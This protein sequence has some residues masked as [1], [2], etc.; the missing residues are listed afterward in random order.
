MI[1]PETHDIF[2]ASTP[3]GVVEI[4]FP[5]TDTDLRAELSGQPAAV[6]CFTDLLGA[7]ENANGVPVSLQNLD[8]KTLMLCCQKDGITITAPADYDADETGLAR[9]ELQKA[10]EVVET[11]EPINR[12]R[13]DVE[14]ADLEAAS[15][16]SFRKAIAVLDGRAVLDSA[17]GGILPGLRMALGL[18]VSALA[19]LPIMADIIKAR[20]GGKT[21][22]FGLKKSGKKYREKINAKVGAL[23]EQIAAGRNVKSLTP[24]E[25]AL[26]R[27]YSGRGGLTDNSQN[28]YYTP[29]P[30]AQGV[31]DLFGA[32][33]FTSGN[34]LEPST[35][36]GVFS[37]TKPAGM[38]ITGTEI[39]KISATVNAAL[40]PEDRILHQP[41]EKLAVSAPDDSFDA[42]I[43]NVP[44]GTRNEGM[45]FDPEH[46]DEKRI[47]RYFVSRVI[48]KTRPGGLIALIV[49]TGIIGNKAGP[50]CKFR[51]MIS[52]KAEFLGAHK[53]PSKTFG[54]QGTDTV[55]DV[56]VLRKHP[57]DLAGKIKHLPAQTLQVANVLWDEFIS[58]GYWLGEGRK[59][60]HGQYIPADKSKVRSMDQVIPDDGATPDTLKRALAVH[61]DSRIDWKMLD[62][63]EPVIPAYAAGDRR[64][65][66]GRDMEFD[67]TR[68]NEVQ[69]DAPEGAI[70]AALYGAGTL[71]ALRLIT[72]DLEGMLSLSSAQAFRVF[73]DFPNLLN[74]QQRMAVE[75]AQSQP[76]DACR[77][78]AFRGSL[79]GSIVARYVAQ[80][81]IGESDD[82]HRKHV[83]E[84][85]EREYAL[86][87]HPRSVK[88]FY[89]EGEAARYFGSYLSAVSE[90]G[91]VSDHLAGGVSEAIGYDPKNM[92]SVVEFLAKVKPDGVLSIDTVKAVY[93]GGEIKSLADVCGVDG[94]SITTNGEI[95]TSARYCAG[96]VYEKAGEFMAAMERETD[97]RVKAQF[98]AQIDL[99]MSKVKKTGIEDISFGLRDRWI[100][101]RYKIDFLNQHGYQF[102]YAVQG[103]KTSA[104]TGETYT[105]TIVS[106][107]SDSQIG[108][109]RLVS[110]AEANG[111]FGRQLEHYMQGRS[112]GFNVKDKGGVSADE[113]IEG[114]RELV[115]NLEEQFIIFMQSHDDFLEIERTY[116][117]TFNNYVAPE[118][119]ASDLGL[120]G[121]SGLVKGHWYQNQ[122]VRQLSEEGAGILGFDVGLGKTYTAIM[123]SLY[124]RQMGRSN[125]HLIVVPKAVL[126][127]WYQESK[128][129]IGNHDG[130]LFVGF[131]PKR[132][133]SAAIVQE[134]VWDENGNHKKNPH[135]GE[136]EYQDVLIE[137]M[138]EEVFAKMHS[139]PQ[140]NVGLVVMTYE[141]YATIPMREENRV[142]Y[143]ESWAE[144]SMM[145]MADLKKIGADGKEGRSYQE[146]QQTDRL[147]AEFS[148]DGTRKKAELPYFEDMGFDRVIVDEC[149]AFKNSFTMGSD[150]ERLAY[151]SNPAPSQRA[152]DMA[153][154]AAWLREKYDGKGVIALTATPVAN[155]P[156]EI[157]NMLSL[158]IDQSEFERLGIYT[159]DDF[160]RQFG[161]IQSV[162]KVR[163]SGEV[164]T[165][166][167]L[168][169]FK[170]LNS[171]RSLF[172]RFAI[173]KNA[174]DVDPDGNV[175]KLPEAVEMMTPVTMSVEQRDLYAA[176]REEA[177]KAG[178]PK[179][180]KSGEAR[181]MFAV[182]RDMDRVTTDIDLYNR[183]MTFI[184][185]AADKDKL[186]A[187]IASLPEE[188]TARVTD[189]DTGEK[190]D[191][192]VPKRAGYAVNGDTIT[193]IAHE[194]YEDAIVS[195]F[196]K[197]KI[198]YASHPL[199]P[200]YA[201][202]IDNMQA[203]LDSKGKQIVF[204][205]EKSQHGKLLRLIINNL[206]VSADQVA[207]INADTAGGE[208]LQ[209]ISDAY[210]RGDIRIIIANKKAEVGVNLQKGTSAIHHMTL[211]W[212]PASI[213][214]RNGRGV[215][216]GNT[217][218]QVRVYYYQAHGSFDEY[219][220]DLLKAKGNWIAALM[221]KNNTNDKAENSAAMGA[222]EQAA[223]LAD[224]REEFLAMV[225]AQ[226]E[227]KEAEARAKRDSAAK[228]NLTKLSSLTSRL[229]S[230]DSDLAAA[231]KSAQDA[232][233]AA[234]R[235]LDK[236]KAEGAD[237]ETIGRREMAV[238]GAEFRAAKV[239]AEWEKKRTDMESQR[240]QA[241]SMLNGMA[242]K[243]E[244]PFDAA[245]LSAPE[246]CLVTT[247]RMVVA[248]GHCYQLPKDRPGDRT[249]VVRVT[250][251]DVG[252][253]T[254]DV[255]AV[256]GWVNSYDGFKADDLFT[257]GTTE[258]KA[259]DEELE[260]L[261][262]LSVGYRYNGLQALGL[263][264]FKAHRAEIRLEGDY[265]LTRNSDG[266]LDASYMSGMQAETVIFPD[267]DDKA[268]EKEL[269]EYLKDQETGQYRSGLGAT[270][271]A[272]IGQAIY[273]PD[274]RDVLGAHLNRASRE[275][276]TA[277]ASAAVQSRIEDMPQATAAEL[278]DVVRACGSS[279]YGAGVRDAANGIVRVW[280][281]SQGY[282]NM[283]EIAGAVSAAM[284]AAQ[285]VLQSRLE[286]MKA[287][288]QRA[289]EAALKSDP[290]YREVS[291]E[292]V[293]KFAAIGLQAVINNEDVVAPGKYG[294]KTYERF[295]S[296]FLKDR[297]AKNGRLYGTKEI[298]KARFGAKWCPEVRQSAEKYG[299]TWVVPATTDLETLYSILA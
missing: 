267:R 154:K 198:E 225:N 276:L 4:G 160:V 298:L 60:I 90:S 129:L 109:F 270:R 247:S 13:G 51:A 239:P 137:D 34:V 233:E 255:E 167:G 2:T 58:G 241:A 243:G 10:L 63:A 272:S 157:F 278:A 212:N 172:H 121:V 71:D 150:S 21:E 221:D 45:Q 146:A 158:I 119:D 86:F 139:I 206:P 69:Y 203:E 17:Q 30:V 180:V 240:K 116:N 9:F 7:C 152:R 136:L 147:K 29:A 269:A 40:H 220:L 205:E 85:V 290:N 166:D 98:Q 174:D 15:A 230:F 286:V 122:G 208:R 195:R 70:D 135:T 176:L 97:P 44:F 190:A 244:L 117:V 169:G 231:K 103:E 226:R 257:E 126:A 108:E 77:E 285:A 223:L 82:D 289:K 217:S 26:F 262:K 14:Q 293:Q 12:A 102:V 294:V 295:G 52:R 118:R 99:M 224:N 165:T 128:K 25:L 188:L 292:W 74:A 120:K 144:K 50:W 132:D 124:D 199:T 100:K 20:A 245:I 274:W 93:E 163:V 211:P 185:K 189:E 148:D 23:V 238:K 281:E 133:K 209:E 91:Q 107:D 145:S 6:S 68:W 47:E 134:P 234:R 84:I 266:L 219:R 43:G 92:R 170:N 162:E 33:G 53:L 178:N 284:T 249:T 232:I 42:V 258:V 179:A 288:E 27:E 283:S 35:G 66:N 143:A 64:A 142:K 261:R 16:A 265:Y 228:V 87:G 65:I 194:V 282:V 277:V 192:K 273:G 79:I 131:E 62:L 207:I 155:S 106:N 246:R 171:L 259:T 130:V 297:N 115:N 48:D 31:W 105:G 235:A 210:N 204:T 138:P 253:R 125:K 123:F 161:M 39:D 164:V 113:R 28:E 46:K 101:A 96:K 159:P 177:K 49:P 59:Y 168:A 279:F 153:M 3:F 197:F 5:L 280:M 89:L 260:V 182:I 19:K 252:T 201:K 218:A 271:L 57:A 22:E 264:F 61:F 36:A 196:K 299:G 83:R 18:A 32:M 200:K 193:Y 263:D 275:D 111:G 242:S 114:Y 181:P 1:T 216:Q 75:F 229:A 37:A 55:T 256:I 227:K 183:T 151:L 24:D 213:Q 73:K 254:V 202:L 38:V 268:L 186:D 173:M 41:F 112:I 222:L 11:N 95:T 110:R 127:N 250:A 78:Q 215:R 175:L 236:A 88:G 80:S 67:G 104:D 56:I 81:N 72:N 248:V 76:L 8:P 251:L 94:V 140:S 214:Q 191:Q 149:H 187:L 237:A 287:D 54:A 291:P 141:K 156:I 184:F 296:L